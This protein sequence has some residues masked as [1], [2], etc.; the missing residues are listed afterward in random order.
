MTSLQKDVSNALR[1]DDVD[2][3]MDV[4]QLGVRRAAAV[5]RCDGDDRRAGD[6]DDA[7]GADA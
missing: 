3:P 2:K 7:G 1:I 5:E 4:R 6:A